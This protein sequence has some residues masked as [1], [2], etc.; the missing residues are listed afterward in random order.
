[1]GALGAL[2]AAALLAGCAGTPATPATVAGPLPDRV[3][4]LT[5]W[6]AP[7]AVP[8][9]GAPGRSAPG[10]DPST[11]AADALL[12]DGWLP[13]T[14]H[15]SKKPTRYRLETRDG[16]TVLR[17]DADSS[18]SGLITRLSIDPLRHPRLSWRW[19]IDSL[20]E[21]ADNTDRHAEDA[22]V[23]VVLGFDGDKST[24]P[25]KDQMFFEQVKL[26]TG[27]DMPYAT[28]MYIWEN[29]KPVGTVIRNPNTDRVRKIVVAS[30]PVGV[31]RWLEFRRDI[32]DD[33]T[34]A[35]GKPP[36][37][38]LVAVAILT[39]TDN[40]RQRVTAWYGDIELD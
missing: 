6:P 36:P 28:L 38:R 5:A 35:Y 20:V 27:R 14:I 30:G 1:M 18:A 26:L 21:G 37:G 4:P 15:A 32:V 11:R 34:L 13:W 3:P 29:K 31:R 19:M 7:R 39:D 40:T 16:R 8:A 9:T 17:A 24:L 12:P 25:L 22:P 23:R 10:G 33:F 2:V